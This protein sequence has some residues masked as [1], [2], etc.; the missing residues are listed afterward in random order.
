MSITYSECVCF[1]ALGIQHRFW[2]SNTGLFISPSGIS[3]IDCATTKTDTA[4]R[5]ISMDREP[6]PSFCPTLQLLEMCNL[7]DAADVD[8]V[9]KFLRHATWAR[10]ATSFRSA[11]AATLLEFHVPFTNCS[12]CRWFCVVHD[13]K[14]PLHRHN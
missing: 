13:P 6:L 4:E 12:V 5:S 11:Q 9:I 14:P 10:T 7:G 1:L 8:P 2:L 3:K